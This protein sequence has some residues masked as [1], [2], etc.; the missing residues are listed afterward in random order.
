MKHRILLPAVAIALITLGCSNESKPRPLS[1]AA[2]NAQPAPRNEHP[3]PMDPMSR[4]DQPGNLVVN[5]SASVAGNRP[6]PFE[7]RVEGFSPV[8][9]DSVTAPGADDR[10]AV[11][12]APT[13]RA[14]TGPSSGQYLEVGGV[15]MDVNGTPIY[16]NKVLRLLDPVFAAAAS[17]YDRETFHKFAAMKIK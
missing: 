8:I 13:S 5:P 11:T 4:T 2:F 3:V 9:Q 1:P 16:A 14:T 15:V 12:T 7:Q 17:Q 6:R 10:S